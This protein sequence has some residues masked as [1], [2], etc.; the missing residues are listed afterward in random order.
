MQVDVGGIKTDFH[1][2]LI[3]PLLQKLMDACDPHQGGNVG[4]FD[5]IDGAYKEAADSENKGDK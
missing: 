1:C 4:A 2:L 3:F 5:R